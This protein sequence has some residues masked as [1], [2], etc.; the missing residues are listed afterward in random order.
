MSFK[1]T[2]SFNRF[3]LATN[4]ASCVATVLLV[5]VAWLSSSSKEPKQSSLLSFGPARADE[6]VNARTA[7]RPSSRSLQEDNCCICFSPDEL[8]TWPDE[9]RYCG[10]ALE[11]NGCAG[12]DVE[13]TIPTELGLAT[14][15]TSLIFIYSSENLVGT[16]PTELGLLTRLTK[17]VLNHID[18]S[19]TIPSELGRLTELLHLDIVK[20]AA[21]P[22][23]NPISD[24]IPT[25]LGLLTKLTRLSLSGYQLTGNIPTQLAFCSDL[26]S[27][28]LGTNRLNGAIPTELG[29]LTRLT[30]LGLEDNRLLSEIPSEMGRLTRLSKLHLQENQLYGPVPFELGLIATPSLNSFDISTN[31]LRGS[32]P[33]SLCTT[34]ILLFI[35]C[36]EVECACGDRCRDTDYGICPP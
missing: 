33:L 13:G 10:E 34:G 16:I 27:I 19:G 17:L 30:A 5:V 3:L 8:C 22:A 31:V 2:S 9:F 7:F 20:P 21:F 23:Q 28:F 14:Q 4:L 11:Y 29:L 18:L 26:V 12:T 24:R 1:N 6:K 35:D 25:E 15:L 36:L 32:I